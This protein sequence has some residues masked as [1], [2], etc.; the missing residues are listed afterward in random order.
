M[1]ATSNCKWTT[2]AS[3]GKDI[4]EDEDG[5]RPGDSVWPLSCWAERPPGSCLGSVLFLQGKGGR[6]PSALVLLASGHPEPCLVP[7]SCGCPAG[8][9]ECGQPLQT[10]LHLLVGKNG[11]AKPILEHCCRGGSLARVEVAGTPW[12]P[13]PSA[14]LCVARR[15][16]CLTSGWRGTCP[17]RRSGK[18][19]YLNNTVNHLGTIHTR[20]LIER[21]ARKEKIHP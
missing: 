3:I 5:V 12:R 15:L 10:A 19:E 16:P 21:S 14:C 9:A 2:L 20:V 18:T 1:R 13:R 7:G 8:G 6:V 4:I 17:C 11:S